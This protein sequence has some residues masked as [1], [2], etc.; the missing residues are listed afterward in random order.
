MAKYIAD[1]SGKQIEIQPITTSASVGG[2]AV[3]KL[4]HTSGVVKIRL[5]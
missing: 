5:T 3:G 4:Y 2:I 1:I